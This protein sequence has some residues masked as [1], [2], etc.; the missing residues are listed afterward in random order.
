[1]TNDQIVHLIEEGLP[2]F[3]R[4]IKAGKLNGLI[5]EAPSQ[6]VFSQESFAPDLDDKEIFI[7]GAAI[8]YAGIHGIEILIASN[9]EA[10]DE[11][12]EEDRQAREGEFYGE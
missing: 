10:M 6:V 1:M 8:K 12:L 5:D 3:A 9:R 11:L 2:E 7:L 4:V